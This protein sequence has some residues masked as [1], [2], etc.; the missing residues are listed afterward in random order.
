[1][2][3]KPNIFVQMLLAIILGALIPFAFSPYNYWFIAPLSLAFF[4]NLIY[5]ERPLWAFGLGIIFGFSFF[6]FGISWIHISLHEFGG[7][8]LALSFFLALLLA[9]YLALYYG[10][11]AGLLTRISWPFTLKYGFLLPFLGTL[12]EVLR[13]HVMTGFP[14]LALGYTL[15]DSPFSVYL[16]PT[17]GALISSFWV[18]FTAGFLFLFWRGLVDQERSLITLLKV[19]FFYALFM[20][21]MVYG[22]FKWGSDT[23][24]VVGDPIEAALVQGNI[25]QGDKFS[26]ASYQETL[27]TYLSLTRQAAVKSELIILPE[28]AFPNFFNQLSLV[29]KEL[30]S[31]AIDEHTN[32]VTGVFNQIEVGGQQE[33]LNSMAYFSPTTNDVA[34][35]NKYKLVP[36]G[37]YIPLRGVLHH[38]NRWIDIPYGDIISGD[39]EQP[40]FQFTF[41]DKSTLPIKGSGSICY[42][43]VFSHVMRYQAKASHFLINISNDAWF[44][45][46][47][48]PWQHLQMARSRA[49]EYARPML[50]S[51][52]T[53]ITAFINHQGELEALAPLF[54]QTIL[55]HQFT[56]MKGLTAYVKWG[57]EI[58]Y[59]ILFLSLILIAIVSPNLYLSESFDRLAKPRSTYSKKDYD[60]L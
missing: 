4:I 44:G 40:P 37:E 56:P 54:S 23:I 31:I 43:A 9:F 1:M 28:T 8:S 30:Q 52:N 26:E 51:T 7:G 55:I 2:A 20:M 42:E 14:W 46:S 36:F 24:E 17:M 21:G 33:V 3:P 50:R 58:W 45:E 39:K 38:F 16:Y 48:G 29:T 13:A 53:G 47:I 25:H 6:G 19:P 27:E 10:V 32:I 15:L 57:D 60:A 11:L 5:K 18:Y 49:L 35:Y 59:F 41:L 22:A 12:L 34:F